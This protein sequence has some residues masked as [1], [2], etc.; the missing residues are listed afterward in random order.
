MPAISTAVGSPLHNFWQPLEAP[1]NAVN[2]LSGPFPHL[3]VFDLKVTPPVLSE[4]AGAAD[5]TEA[6]LHF[7]SDANIYPAA[8][9][10]S[11]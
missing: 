11:K 8:A 6:A 4:A 1:F 7:R 2:S 9:T 3:S 10:F 5:T